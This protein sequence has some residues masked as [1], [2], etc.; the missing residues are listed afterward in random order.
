ME[1]LH[2]KVDRYLHDLSRHGDPVLA[3]MEERAAGSGF[4]IVGPLA[5]RFC[6]QV[7]RMVG[8]R[9]VFELGSGYGYSTLW[10]ARA[11][12]ENGGGEVFHTVWDESL[13]RD[14][15]QYI[16]EAGLSHLVR[17]RVSEAVSALQET[18]GPFDLI[19]N[20]INKDLYPAS[21]PLIKERLRPGGALLIDNMLWHGRLFDPADRDPNT[22]GV[23]EATRMLFNDPDYFASLVPLRDGLILALKR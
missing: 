5:G 6:Y 13:S 11:V 23:R 4:P 12:A 20:D 1:L 15:Q 17:F 21:L 2:P 16:G 3:K 14:A 19:F 18:P 9:R 7:A 22:E 8:A 10:F